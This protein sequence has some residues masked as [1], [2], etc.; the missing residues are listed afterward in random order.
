[1]DCLVDIET[2]RVD[3]PDNAL[4]EIWPPVLVVQGDQPLGD[5]W[6]HMRDVARQ[7]ES[8]ELQKEYSRDTR[9]LV[10]LEEF[11][12]QEFKVVQGNACPRARRNETLE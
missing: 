7:H 5:A 11:L 9:I 12:E 10:L 3:V 8:L 1:M 4:H 6:R 2:R